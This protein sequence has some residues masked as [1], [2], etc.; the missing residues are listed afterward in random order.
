MMVCGCCG[1]IFLIAT[2]LMPGP[3]TGSYSAGRPADESVYQT[4]AGFEPSDAP[5]GGWQDCPEGS[6]RMSSGT[7]DRSGQGNDVI[8]VDG[9]VLTLPN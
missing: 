1:G 7:V 8:S 5:A 6:G 4:A 2:L 9:Q 3:D